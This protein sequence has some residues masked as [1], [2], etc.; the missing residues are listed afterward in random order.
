MAEETGRSNTGTATLMSEVAA[1]S[2]MKNDRCLIYYVPSLYS[3]YYFR[4]REIII[5]DG[6]A[7]T[8]DIQELPTT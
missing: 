1:T 7:V 8:L 3:T 5:I 6:D 2:S 4:N